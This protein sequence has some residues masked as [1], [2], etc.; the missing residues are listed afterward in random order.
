MSN[1]LEMNRNASGTRPDI[2]GMV[3][4]AVFILLGGACL[5]QTTQMLDPDSYVF[6]RMVITALMGLS[7]VLIVTS[8]LKPAA[9]VCRT[10]KD[11]ARPSAWRRILLVVSMLA[12]T[13]MMPFIGFLLSGIVVFITLMFLANHDAW[14]RGKSILYALIGIAIV[15]GFYGAFT[16]FLQ[17]SLPHGAWL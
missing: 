13:L 6:P 8:L 15:V 14:G 3:C 9:A 1:S 2:G 7:L 10:G 11:Q 5:Y 12:A 4:A 16:Y 17:V